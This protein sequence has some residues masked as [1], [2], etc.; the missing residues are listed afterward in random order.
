MKN[1]KGLFVAL[2]YKCTAVCKKCITRYHKFVNKEM[3]YDTMDSLIKF[4][5][6]INYSGVINL[7]SGEPLIYP[8]IEEFLD[9]V[10]AINEKVNIR[11]LTNGVLFNY[12]K[13]K[14]WIGNERVTFGVTFDGFYQ[15]ELEG[16]QHG[17]DIEKVKQQIKSISLNEKKLNIY[18]NYTVHKKNKPSI[19]DFVKFASEVG[20]QE[21]YFTNLK[22]IGG[23]EAI[24]DTVIL[25]KND[26]ELLNKELLNLCKEYPKIKIY[27][28]ETDVKENWFCWK[29]GKANPIIDIDGTVTFCVG[30]EDGYVGNIVDEDLL[31]KWEHKYTELEQ[32]V[33]CA[34][35]WCKQCCGRKTQGEYKV[36]QEVYPYLNR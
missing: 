27:I 35:R 10:L 12:E 3:M 36:S 7:G 17:V 1:N 2:T 22:K 13:C 11:L 25:S 19:S 18:L 33:Q 32:D 26:M 23:V 4:L 20:I 28:P 16:L 34:K 9:R 21:V 15:E 5:E 8:Y 14:K 31:T 30:R 24:I 6:E 29:K